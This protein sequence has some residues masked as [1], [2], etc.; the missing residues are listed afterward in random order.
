MLAEYAVEPAAIGSD[1]RTFKDLIDRF[2]ADKGRLISRFPTKW[3]KK[4]IQAAKDSG[5]PDIR[6]AS[7][8]Q[9]LQDSKQKIADFNRSYVHD[10]DW[11]SNAIREHRI[12]PFKAIICGASGLPCAEAIQPDDCTDGNLLFSAATSR[13]VTRTAD[14]IADAL[15]MIAAV[16]EA[17]DIVDPFFDLRSTKGYLAPL[18][19]L[20]AR[21]ARGPG[22]PKV[23]RIHFRDHDARPP[24][25]V[26]ARDGSAQVRGM[27]PPGYSLELYAWSEIPGGRI[28]MT[29]SC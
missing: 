3:E 16:S 28:F 8:I 13:S 19:S 5:V 12:T 15:Y 17:V 4:V 26:L 22:Q 24:A 29:A 2:G 9:R 14:E 11:I 25:A 7:I 23:I 27:L 20:L 10:A 1:W 6:I 18:A 21:L